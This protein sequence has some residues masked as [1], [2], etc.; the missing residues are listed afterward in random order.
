VD[1]YRPET[2]DDLDLHPHISVLLKKMCTSGNFPHLLVYG[3][4]GCGKKTRVMAMLQQLYGPGV[5]KLKLEQ[6]TFQASSKALEL[7]TISS[8]Y[9]IELNPSDGGN[10]DRQVVQEVIKD[11]AQS[12]PLD[13]HRSFKV[14]VLT[15][16]DKLSKE[17]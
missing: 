7:F 12:Q 16:V 15:E 3:T 13:D 4:S 2:L 1:K 17:A 8:P 14:V 6:R 10:Y 11:I 5:R 9:H